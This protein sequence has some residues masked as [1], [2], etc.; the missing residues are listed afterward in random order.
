MGLD[1]LCST[2]RSFL[3]FAILDACIGVLVVKNGPNIVS[4]H[5]ELSVE[6]NR[7]SEAYDKERSLQEIREKSP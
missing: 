5:V 3:C 4:R 1:S 2:G 6:L 7:S